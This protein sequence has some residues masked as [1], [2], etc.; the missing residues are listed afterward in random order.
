MAE[1]VGCMDC[2]MCGV[3][4][5][6]WCGI[7]V[8]VCDGVLLRVLFGNCYHLVRVLNESHSQ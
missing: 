8:M 2:V 1:F 7:S 6:L 4:I 5:G 3:V